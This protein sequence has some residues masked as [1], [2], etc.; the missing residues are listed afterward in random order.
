MM[1]HNDEQ[2]ECNDEM[3]WQEGQGC[4][5][6]MTMGGDAT[7]RRSRDNWEDRDDNNK[8]VEQRAPRIFAREVFLFCV[9]IIN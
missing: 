1:R 3:Q 7:M 4:N 2:Q 6:A 8:R 9:T 5:D